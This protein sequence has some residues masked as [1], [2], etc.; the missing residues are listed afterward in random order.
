MDREQII[1]AWKD[2]EYRTGLGESEGALLPEHP[3]GVIEIPDNRMDE[4]A[5]AFTLGTCDFIMSFYLNGTCS[6]MTTGCCGAF[7]AAAD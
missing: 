5:G 6:N 3:A 2:E 1:R 7:E 4:A